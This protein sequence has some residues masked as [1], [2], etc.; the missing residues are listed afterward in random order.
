[1][2]PPPPITPHLLTGLYDI[3][4]TRTARSLGFVGPVLVTPPVW[5]LCIWRGGKEPHWMDR[6]NELLTSLRT[7]FY[8]AGEE[9]TYIITFAP[10]FEAHWQPLVATMALV[11]G[12]PE[13]HVTLLSQAKRL[14]PDMNKAPWK[15]A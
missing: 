4:E 5:Y 12:K 8:K 15:A 9:S 14:W 11:E 3:G 2:P 10:P 1:M 7:A 13:F 6:V